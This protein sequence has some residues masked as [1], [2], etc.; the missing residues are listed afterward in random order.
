MGVTSS[1]KAK[2]RLQYPANKVGKQSLVGWHTFVLQKCMYIYF[3]CT[4]LLLLVGEDS[5]ALSEMSMSECI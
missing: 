2:D 1:P 4:I 5:S 3:M